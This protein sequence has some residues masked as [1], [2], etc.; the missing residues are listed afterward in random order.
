MRYLEIAEVIKLVCET[1]NIEEIYSP[2]TI[3]TDLSPK[4]ICSNPFLLATVSVSEI[5]NAWKI[6]AIRSSALSS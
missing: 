5:F 4:L 2:V 3:I 6:P 1:K